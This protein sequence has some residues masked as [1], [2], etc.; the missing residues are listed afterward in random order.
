MDKIQG[1]VEVLNSMQISAD[2]AGMDKA[3]KELMKNKEVLAVILKG[4]VQEYQDY[5]YQ[6]I[7]DFIEGDSIT[8][9]EEITAGRNN[10]RIVGDDKEYIMLGEKTSNFDTKFRAVNPKLSNESM[11]I[12]LHID[13]ESQKKYNPGYPIEK[14][15]IYYLAREL[16]AQFS[17]VTEETD[18]GQLE[19]CYSI[20]ICRDDI[21]KNEKFSISFYEISNKKNY[22]NCA[23]KKEKYDLLNLVVIRLGDLVY[24]GVK[25]DM[26]YDVFKFL[27]TIMYPHKEDFLDTV[28]EYIDFSR[29]EILWKEMDSMTGLGMSILEE[30]FEKGIE[31][32]IEQGELINSKKIFI[33]CLKRGDSKQEAMDFAEI[34]QALADELYEEFKREKK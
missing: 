34:E 28:K 17:V 18:Y 29:N 3:S 31:Q 14:R 11:R 30:G 5:S 24:N 10:S 26:G 32:G 9:E 23:P 21:P 15:G 33:K 20:F 13:I 12:Y 22:G 27:H 1:S 7:M 6:E 8:D 16:S 25:E 19:K 2:T 4:V